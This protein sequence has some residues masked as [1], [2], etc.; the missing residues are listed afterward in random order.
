MTVSLFGSVHGRTIE[1]DQDPGVAEGQRVEIEIRI[2]P[3]NRSKS[4]PGPPEG[5]PNRHHYS[6]AGVLALVC[7]NE[8]ESI[9]LEIHHSRKQ[10]SVREV[11]E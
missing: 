1:L 5:W 10:D 3:Q 2:I 8:D 4:L 9:L 7:T 6:G 11:L